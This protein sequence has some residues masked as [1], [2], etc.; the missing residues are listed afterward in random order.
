MKFRTC[1]HWV[2]VGCTAV[3]GA[4]GCAP[5]EDGES[6]PGPGG[7]NETD[8]DPNARPGV[9]PEGT[10]M[11]SVR[12]LALD[13]RGVAG[14]AILDS[15]DAAG[16]SALATPSSALG[17]SSGSSSGSALWL[18]SSSAG[19]VISR[20]GTA[21]LDATS[22]RTALTKRMGLA[23]GTRPGALGSWAAQQDPTEPEPTEPISDGNG[24]IG[25]EIDDSDATTQS[26]ADVGEQ[27]GLLKI[28]DDG[29]IAPALVEL[30]DG[31][32]SDGD[33]LGDGGDDEPTTSSGEVPSA[34]P[35]APGSSDP[36]PPP[37]HH[38]PVPRVTAV[39][40]SP[41]GGVYILFERSFTYRQPTAEE[42]AS[43]VDVMAPGSPSRCQLFR[44]NGDWQS[45]AASADPAELE[46]I[47]NHEVDTW[48]SR[49]V[50]Q[51]DASGKLYFR[52]R[53]PG[54]P[55]EVFYQYDPLTQALSEKVNGNICWRD[56]QVTPRGSL[57]YTGISNT[58]GECSGTS[59]FRYVSTDNRLTEIAR[60]WWNFKYLAEQDPDD[61][62]N[63]RIIFY[64]PDPNAA[65]GLGWETACLYRYN[66]AAEDPAQRTQKL[67]DC[68]NDPYTYVL[69]PNPAG[70]SGMDAE[71]LS[72]FAGRCESEGQLFVGGQG[73]SGLSQL[74]DGTLFVVGDFQRKRAG[75]VRCALNVT[76]AHCTSLDPAH[77]DESSCVDAGGTW[78]DLDPYCSNPTYTDE[79]E[80]T[81]NSGIWS[82]GAPSSYYDNVTGEACYAARS[83][84][85]LG[86][87]ECHVDNT[88]AGPYGGYVDL[89]SGLG[90]LTPSEEGGASELVLLSDP[91]ES[92]ER[93]WPVMG[94]SGAE[95]YYS[96]YDAGRYSLRVATQHDAGEGQVEVQRRGVLDDYEVY[97]VER[98]PADPNRVLFD[99]LRFSTN[100]YLFGSA[101]TTLGTPAEVEA[102]VQELSG[103]SGRVETLI[104]LP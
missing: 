31:A 23:R 16:G 73:V 79:S 63:E 48:D 5:S 57:F 10:G 62:N 69:G 13:L 70:P 14:F 44:A 83:G 65:T 43:G 6:G 84:F 99:A 67:L 71:E 56:V 38:E 17:G 93:Y 85:D 20:T 51:F 104:V 66:P 45:A 1:A 61:P 98:D 102:S 64:G 53:T 9:G 82:N 74:D 80:C 92:V 40:L 22:I 101:D 7:P 41:D 103:V 91:A 97:N 30:D 95:L 33:P 81:N 94:P 75:Q 52:G 12:R 76:V 96:V 27:T 72:A 87:A 86:Y 58:D 28:T 50:M 68:V 46:C 3:W 11:P 47:T 2:L 42:L 32:A 49:R 25:A 29:E 24:D 37:Q 15:A 90:Y 26:D 88:S 4:A 36:M 34:D 39:G 59:F 55:R 54:S 21:P 18:G 78:V 8:G 100:K 60:D 19:Q 89:V 77:D 35:L